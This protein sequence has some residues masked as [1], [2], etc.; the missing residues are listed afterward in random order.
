LSDE[1]IAAHNG[2]VDFKKLLTLLAAF[3]VLLAPMVSNAN[4]V[5]SV[6]ATTQ[7]ATMTTHDN[8]SCG[9]ILPAVDCHAG[10][11]GTQHEKHHGNSKVSHNCC[12]SFVGIVSPTGLAIAT[13]R[14]HDHIPFSPSLRLTTRVEGLYRP[15]RQI[16]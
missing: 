12:F 13:P 11:S 4:I 1:I 8:H 16:T 5:A 2:P 10:L 6:S 7:T 9:D 14:H 3:C 15:P